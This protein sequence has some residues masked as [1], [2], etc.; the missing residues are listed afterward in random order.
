MSSKN[1]SKEIMKKNKKI[2]NKKTMLG[3]K[4]AYKLESM[5][6]EK[7]KVESAFDYFKQQK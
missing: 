1:K 7:K 6:K 2:P 4:Q 3:N 5:M